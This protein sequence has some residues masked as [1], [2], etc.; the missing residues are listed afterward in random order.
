MFGIYWVKIILSVIKWPLKDD[1]RVWKRLENAFYKF[2]EKD[3]ERSGWK[4]VTE[5]VKRSYNK[6]L[7]NV[8]AILATRKSRDLYEILYSKEIGQLFSTHTFEP[9]HKLY[10]RLSN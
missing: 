3:S 8:I 4:E 2:Q 6:G 9:L 10:L 5:E 1:S 7:L